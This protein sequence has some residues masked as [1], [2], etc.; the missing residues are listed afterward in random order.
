MIIYLNIDHIDILN[1]LSTLV[2]FFYQPI[3]IMQIKGCIH[4]KN[5]TRY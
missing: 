4:L 5:T 3:V 2:L 1:R